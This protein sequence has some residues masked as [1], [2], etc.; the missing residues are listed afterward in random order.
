MKNI[1]MP[2]EP[3]V[4]GRAFA[5]RAVRD[6]PETGTV[7]DYLWLGQQG[8]VFEPVEAASF[9]QGEAAGSGAES[10]TGADGSDPAKPCLESTLASYSSWLDSISAK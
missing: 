4:V 10:A 8:S 2:E 5:E 1:D 3:V 6:I 7:L 9:P